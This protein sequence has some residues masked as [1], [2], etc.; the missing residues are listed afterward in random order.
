MEDVLTADQLSFG[1]SDSYYIKELS[2]RFK[3]REVVSIIGPNG[4]GKSTVLR[5]LTRLLK[6]AHGAVYLEGKE[7]HTL[8]S[9]NIAK[10]LTML[11]Q[12]YDHRSEMTVRDLVKFG[13]QPHLKWY[14]DY[15]QSHDTYIDWALEATRLTAL[16]HRPLSSLSGG[17]R[18][19]AW[20]A[21]TIAQT[22]QI[23]LLDEPTS[24]L[25]IAHQLEVME[26]VQELNRS[27]GLTI[28]MVLHDLNQAARYSDQIIAMKNGKVV[29]QGKP[30]D[31][32]HPDFFRDVFSIEARVYSAGEYPVCEPYGVVQAT[33]S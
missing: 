32:Y 16:Q 19:R 24:Y 12:I 22:P 11:P 26:L 25:D 8:S 13:R 15:H 20:I 31:V 3:K 5:L 18:Q 14:E 1:F 29:R 33:Q 4:S 10:K 9:K 7:L 28:I 21:M 30:L 23:L 2:L 17:E 27:L 6:P